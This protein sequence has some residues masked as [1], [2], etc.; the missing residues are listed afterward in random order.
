MSL[1][2][3]APCCVIVL[4]QQQQQNTD[5]YNQSLD[6]DEH[7]VKYGKTKSKNCTVVEN[8]RVVVRPLQAPIDRA[9]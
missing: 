5:H 2:I 9:D 8:G 7:K 1:P 4:N 3:S 6:D